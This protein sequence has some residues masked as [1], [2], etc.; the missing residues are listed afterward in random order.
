MKILLRIVLLML[1]YYTLRA[2]TFTEFYVQTTGDN[3][4][5]GS[6]TDNAATVTYSGGSWVAAS[7]IFY[8]TNGN[9]IVDTALGQWAS[10]YT[11]S[12]ATVATFIGRITGTNATSLTVDLSAIA[13]SA[14][15]PSATTNACQCKVGGAWKGPNAA[16]GFPFNFATATL[17]NASGNVPRVNF[18]SGVTYAITA[19]MTASLAGPII[20]RGYTSAPGDD[21]RATIDGGNPAT[22]FTLLNLSGTD[23]RVEQFIF[24]NSGQSGGTGH[25]MNIS[26]GRYVINR[27]VAHNIYLC[28]FYVSATFGELVECEAYG[29]GV[30]TG[31]YSAFAPGVGCT[32][33]RCISHDNT[34]ASGTG[35]ATA[36]GCTFINCI[37]ESNAASG[38]SVQSTGVAIIGCDLYN[39]ATSGVDIGLA[40]VSNVIIENC[41]FIKNGAYGIDS[42]GSAIRQGIIR[43]CGF[44]T[45]TQ[46]NGVADLG[47][48]ITGIQSGIVVSDSISYGANLTPW[49]D[50]ANGDFRLN[51]AGAK[52]TG[53]GSFTQ[54]QAAYAGTVAYPDVGAAQH[55]ESA[56]T[57]GGSYPFAQ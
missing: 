5:A 30:K 46:K 7:G 22:A 20:W 37:S 21:G 51:L 41:N 53:R 12:G 38:I 24:S 15:A 6:T 36:N 49:V 19:A 45:G 39:N 57:G 3:L 56:A 40:T 25:A 29:C 18:K 33:L 26:G 50:P 10:I 27:V 47:P 32:L 8:P 17:T 42:S 1:V 13:G 31:G 35:F 2:T 9:P 43:N 48:N 44:G 14:A 52:G 4:N 54:T 28:G 55:L 11:Q 34:G 23:Q 16:V